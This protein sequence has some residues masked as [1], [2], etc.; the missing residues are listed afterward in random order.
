MRYLGST[1]TY[2]SPDGY[3]DSAIVKFV[4]TEHQIGFESFGTITVVT[5]FTV[6]NGMIIERNY[7]FNEGLERI[8]EPGVYDMVIEY[9]NEETGIS[10]KIVIKEFLKITR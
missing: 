2:T 3:L 6:Y 8:N 10:D 9:V 1:F 4:N 5:K 7:R